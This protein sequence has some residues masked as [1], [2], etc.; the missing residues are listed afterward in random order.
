MYIKIRVSTIRNYIWRQGPY[1]YY[2][3]G[4]SENIDKKLIQNMRSTSKEYETI[5]VLE[6]DWEEYKDYEPSCTLGKVN[7]VYLTFEGKKLLEETLPDLDQIK[8]I[9]TLCALYHNKKIHNFIDRVKSW[10]IHKTL[11]EEFQSE[12]PATKEIN[13]ALR[14]YFLQ[15][16][17]RLLKQKIDIEYINESSEIK[18]RS[19]NLENKN[20][21]NESININDDI[22]CL[23]SVSASEE[24]NK[25]TSEENG[26]KPILKSFEVKQILNENRKHMNNENCLPEIEKIK[27]TQN[28]EKLKQ[29]R[30]YNFR[31]RMKDINNKN[32][33]TLKQKYQTYLAE[34]DKKLSENNKIIIKLGKRTCNNSQNLNFISK[35]QSDFKIKNY[36]FS[37]K[38]WKNTSIT[39]LKKL[40]T[41]KI[42]KHSEISSFKLISPS[43]KSK[44]ID[45][46]NSISYTKNI[47]QTSNK[48]EYTSTFTAENKIKISL[49]KQNFQ[50]N[51]NQIKFI[52]KSQKIASLSNIDDT[53]IKIPIILKSKKSLTHNAK[54]YSDLETIGFNSLLLK[55][56]NNKEDQKYCPK[57]KDV[58]V[59]EP[60]KDSL[61]NETN[62]DH[63]FSKNIISLDNF[64]QMMKKLKD[65][66]NKTE[67]NISSSI[68]NPRFITSEK[69]ESHIQ[70]TIEPQNKYKN[71]SLVQKPP[72][73]SFLNPLY[74]KLRENNKL[75]KSPIG[76]NFKE[77]EYGSG[78]DKSAVSGLNFP[79]EAAPVP[80]MQNFISLDEFKPPFNKIP[81]I[82]KDILNDKWEE[83]GKD[84]KLIHIPNNDG[85][86]TAINVCTNL[87][88]KKAL[89][90][91]IKN[92]HEQ[93]KNFQ[94]TFVRKN[95]NNITT[96]YNIIN[97]DCTNS[98][99]KTI[100]KPNTKKCIHNYEEFLFNRDT[101]KPSLEIFH[102]QDYNKPLDLRIIK[103]VKPS[104]NQ[105]NNDTNIDENYDFMKKYGYISDNNEYSKN[106]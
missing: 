48:K 13:P 57:L 40:K 74:L 63:R 6:M 99:S 72:I 45:K 90:K 62:F 87:P 16:K 95:S 77:G 43:K 86:L 44:F 88:P 89:I 24:I 85:K 51:R 4:K 36:K 75:L 65:L 104:S 21:K 70:K 39:R 82:N 96:K 32:R 19:I 35:H 91:G 101:V 67:E 93:E 12:I 34:K 66:E 9:F 10:V 41:Q 14:R 81:K 29:E 46:P 38:N 64:P 37:H 52:S 42:R 79:K 31:G 60:N 98:E 80:N 50:Q 71:L 23:K 7:N 22:I 28:I 58:I 105:E 15:R 33:Y 25:Y 106:K 2:F 78:I 30:I 1:I 102:C 20:E 47:K 92:Y 76:H 103:D 84:T 26:S 49:V 53:K 8:K 100:S 27:K 59:A 17:S 3:T 83:I 18:D 94:K 55:E 11:E 97:N 73:C 5:R 61:K 68:S 54:S 69:I 56:Y